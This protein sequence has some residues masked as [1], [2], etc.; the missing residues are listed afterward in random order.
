GRGAHQASD[1]PQLREAVFVRQPV[2]AVGL[3][4][5]VEGLQRGLGSGELRDVGRLASRLAGV[6][7]FCAPDGGKPA[8]FNGDVRLGKRMSDALMRADRRRPY[9]TL[10]GIVGGLGDGV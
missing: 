3:D 2:A 5:L 7:E 9:L 10:L 1:E 8:Q 4:G 6:E